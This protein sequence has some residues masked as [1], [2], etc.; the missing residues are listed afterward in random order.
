MKTVER[1]IS[2]TF[3]ASVGR[4]FK[5]NVLKLGNVFWEHEIQ[6]SPK[7]GIDR[8]KWV[9]AKGRKLTRILQ[10]FILRLISHFACNIYKPIHRCLGGKPI[11]V[12]CWEIA[13]IKRTIFSSQN[14]TLVVQSEEERY[15]LETLHTLLCECMLKIKCGKSRN[16]YFALFWFI[17]VRI[18]LVL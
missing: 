16:F 13:K 11:S 7:F 15:T 2:E 18:K 10:N 5:S 9:S 3:P 14:T 1:T 4:F 6:R 17:P 8:S 12:N